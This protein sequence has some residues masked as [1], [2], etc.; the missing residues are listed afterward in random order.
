MQVAERAQIINATHMIIVFVGY[1]HRIQPSVETDTKHLL[2][3]IG[4]AIPKDMAL[5]LLHKC[6]ATQT[7]IARVLTCADSA[8]AAGRGA[9]AG[10]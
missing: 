8:V 1:E 5:A 3:E 2:A 9:G 4:T 6:R 7:A 10:R